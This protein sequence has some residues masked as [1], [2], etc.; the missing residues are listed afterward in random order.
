MKC[1]KSLALAL[2]MTAAACGGPNPT[3]PGA[4]DTNT[5]QATVGAQQGSAA[6]TLSPLGRSA[7][8]DVMV[9]WSMAGNNFDV[10][11]TDASCLDYTALSLPTCLALVAAASPTAKPE[12]LSFDATPSTSYKVFV[13]NRGSAT[14]TVTVSVAIH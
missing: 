4:G 7:T 10:Y 8:V 2:G 5:T 14:D 6:V 13:V 9:D 12:R 11:V 3:A 1:F